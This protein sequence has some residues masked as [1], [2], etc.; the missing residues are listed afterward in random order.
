MLELWFGRARPLELRAGTLT[1]AVPPG[2][3]A[4]IERRYGFLLD[5]AVRRAGA[6]IDRVAIADAPIA[7]APGS[8]APL[9][10]NPLHTFDR[11][12]IGPGNRLA[13]A[14]A[15]H[16]AELPGEAYNPLF[17]HGPPGLGKTHLLGAIAAYLAEHR[18]DL[19]VH[20]TTAERFTTEFVTC[21]R[22]AGPDAFKRRYRS[23]DALLIDDV[24]ALE[25]K[26]H[27]EAEFVDTF[28]ALHHERKQIVLSSDRPPDALAELAARLRD[29]FDW[30]L[31]VEIHPPDLRTRLTL[32]WRMASS[33]PL[34]LREPGALSAI[35]SSVPDNVRRL[36]G[37]MTR[38][39]AR[40]SL[41]S[42]P[43]S[44]KLVASALGATGST[45][46]S[47][48]RSPVPDLA[49]IQAAVATATGVPLP[50]LTSK[51]RSP[52]VAAARQLAMYLTNEITGASITDIA[53]GFERDH[54]TVIHALRRVGAR[55]EPGSPTLEALHRSRRELG[56]GSSPPAT[57]IPAHA[58]NPQPASTAASPATARLSGADP[59]P[60]TPPIHLP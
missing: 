37:A 22:Q 59:H 2:D 15:L 58:P 25:G 24:Q 13:H 16:T 6:G 32:L 35:A 41:F 11:F 3:R 43:I 20:Y 60:S 9:T 44:H 50:A 8:P 4:W 53:R 57:V 27:T 34:D 40:A 26:R 51:S 36:E 21:L 1:V 33:L 28:N 14:A 47:R 45:S 29:R 12:V 54:T 23:L 31:T 52:R 10:A 48:R 49:A 5:R 19:T 30:G 39:A 17:L 42:E 7:A 46:A 55:L 18:P 56:I 38:V